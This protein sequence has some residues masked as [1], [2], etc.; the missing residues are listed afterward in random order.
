VLGLVV[1]LAGAYVY[2]LPTNVRVRS[3]ID[4]VANGGRKEDFYINIEFDRLAPV[5]EVL[6]APFP[7]KALQ[8]G[9]DQVVRAELFRLRNAERDIIGLAT[10]MTGLVPDASGEPVVAINWLVLVPGRGAFTL[11]QGPALAADLLPESA[12]FEQGEVVVGDGEFAGLSGSYIEAILSEDTD[13]DGTQE[14]VLV[15]STRMA[16]GDSA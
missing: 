2:P 11:S 7:E 6:A 9:G 12:R 5:Q 14:D 3:D 4:P 1:V 8:S 10:R 13:G 16:S 15:L